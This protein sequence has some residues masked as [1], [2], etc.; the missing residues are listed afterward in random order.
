MLFNLY[1]IKDWYKQVRGLNHSALPFLIGTKYDQFTKLTKEEQEDI[2]KFAR[3]FAKAMKAPLVF[4]S[5]SHSIN[6]RKI[7]KIIISKVFA[8]KCTI[9]EIKNVGEPILE[10]QY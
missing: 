4:T 8:L 6:I 10:Y 5:A 7:F 2:C 9:E 3:K 1:S